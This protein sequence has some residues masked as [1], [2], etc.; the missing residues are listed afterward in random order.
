MRANPK[1]YAP[2]HP[3][4]GPGLRTGGDEGGLGRQVVQP[5]IGGRLLDDHIGHA[6]AV[7]CTPAFAQAQADLL[8]RMQAPGDLRVVPL[9][10]E[11]A[12]VLEAHGAPA[13]LL[14][15]DRYVHAL[16]R[17][18]DDLRLALAGLPVR[19]D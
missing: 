11:L 8:A 15:P 1:A 5:R 2:P 13:L 12:P 6:F 7:V 3:A 19:L 9:P 17:D 16:L 14:R 10:P 4:L 18:G